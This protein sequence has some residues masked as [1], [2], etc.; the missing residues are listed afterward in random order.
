MPAEGLEPPTNGL[1]NR[2]STAELI[3]LAR[4]YSI[5]S[6]DW[7]IGSSCVPAFPPIAVVQRLC[8]VQVTGAKNVGA[9]T[10]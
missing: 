2:C 4:S 3:R 10:T 1:Q 9:N 6:S 5:N 7:G 8:V